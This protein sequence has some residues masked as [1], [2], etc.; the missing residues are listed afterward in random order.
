MNQVRSRGS[1]KMRESARPVY[2]LLCRV[3]SADLDHVPV[4]M[5]DERHGRSRFVGDRGGGDQLVPLDAVRHLAGQLAGIRERVTPAG[6]R[7]LEAQLARSS[8]MAARGR[9]DIEP[10]ASS[11]RAEARTTNKY[12]P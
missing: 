9:R 10:E 5:I 1:D 7:T 11:E 8:D 2:F 12:S 4:Q 6:V 3:G